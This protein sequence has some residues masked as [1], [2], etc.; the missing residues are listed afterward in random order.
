MKSEQAV[1]PNPWLEKEEEE[2]FQDRD[3]WRA[4]VITVM[5][6]CVP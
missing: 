2:Y 1:L 6:L 3:Q 5:N 4:L